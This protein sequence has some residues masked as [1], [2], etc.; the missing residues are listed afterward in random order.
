MRILYVN[1]VYPKGSTGTIV[2]I[3]NN[4]GQKRGDETE[5]CYG[6]GIKISDRNAYKFSFD[7]ETLLHCA[8]TRVTG[9]TGS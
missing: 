3:L 9:F 2:H 8:M 7:I 1:S 4:E 6:R 5:V